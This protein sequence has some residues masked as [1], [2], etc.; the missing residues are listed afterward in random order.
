[1]QSFFLYVKKIAFFF[2][3]QSKIRFFVLYKGRKVS[4]LLTK[5]KK[6]SKLSNMRIINLYLAKST[7]IVKIWLFK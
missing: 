2:G 6:V 4:K 7:F 1:M 5:K 3:K